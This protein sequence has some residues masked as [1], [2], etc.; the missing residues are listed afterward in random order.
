MLPQEAPKLGLREGFPEEVALALG[1]STFCDAP[2]PDPWASSPEPGAADCPAGGRA[3]PGADPTVPAH[4]LLL[5]LQSCASYLETLS[6][7]QTVPPAKAVGPCMS[8]GLTVRR[9]WNSLLK[10]AMLYQQMLSQV[11]QPPPPQRW[12]PSHPAAQHRPRGHVWAPG[13]CGTLGKTPPP[14]SLSLFACTMGVTRSP[15]LR[16]LLGDGVPLSTI[17]KG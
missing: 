4:R 9:F 3:G 12:S 2:D 7:E 8:V 11:G 6:A 1:L 16:A 17:A 5:L 10:L 15:P 14:L 13:P